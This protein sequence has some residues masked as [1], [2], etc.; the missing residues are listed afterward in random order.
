MR[1]QH[2]WDDIPW[3]EVPREGQANLEEIVEYA[4]QNGINHFETA[5]GYGSSE[6]QLGAILPRYPRESLIVQTKVAPTPE[7]KDFLAGFDQSMEYLQLDY[8]DLLGLHGINNEEVLERA[9]RPGGSLEAAQR[10][11]EQGRARHIGFSTHARP[12]V[13]I[14]AIESDAFDYVNLH[15]YFVNELTWPAVEAAA[16]QDMGV[17]IISPNDKGGKLYEAPQRLKD[18]CAPLHPM[19]FNDL[20]CWA[21]PQVHLLSMGASCPEDFDTHLE[22]VE[23]VGR[24]AEIVAPIEQR[25]SKSDG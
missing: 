12:E 5:R 13:I 11:K 25:L 9:L 8:V 7:P 21:R 1:F 2:K 17:F 15:W 20:F 6:M 18:L 3:K 10:L 24:A 19:Q 14:E 23:M 22:A 4:E 16:R